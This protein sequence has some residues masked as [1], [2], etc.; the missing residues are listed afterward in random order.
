MWSGASSFLALLLS[1]SVAFGAV[2]TYETQAD[3]DF[4]WEVGAEGAWGHPNTRSEIRLNYHRFVIK[5]I[6]RRQALE[7]QEALGWTSTTRLLIWH[8]GFCWIGEVLEDELGLQQVIGIEHSA[9]IQDAKS[10]NEDADLATKVEDVGLSTSSS[11]GLTLFNAFRNNGNPRSLRPANILN[12]PLDTS[13]SR[14]KVRDLMGGPGYEIMTHE[15]LASLEDAEIIALG[16][17]LDKATNG[18]ISH[19][20]DTSAGCCFIGR[21]LDEYKALIPG[22][23]FIST[24]TFEVR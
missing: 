4:L 7:L 19:L 23:F 5:P 3:W 1:S 12:E 24:S 20:V 11:D 21:T 18:R 8:C 14:N 13:A 9:Y 16:A 2:Y 17:L 6:Q 22:H 15:F 10:T